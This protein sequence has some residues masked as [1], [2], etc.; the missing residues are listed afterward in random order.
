[1]SNGTTHQLRMAVVDAADI[2]DLSRINRLGQMLEQAEWG[3]KAGHINFDPAWDEYPL[4]RLEKLFFR[5]C[6]RAVVDEGSFF[7]LIVGYDAM[8]SSLCDK[9]KDTLEIRPDLQALV[10]DGEILPVVLEALI[11][12][13]ATIEVMKQE[14]VQ[15]DYYQMRDITANTLFQRGY[16]V[17]E[18]HEHMENWYRLNPAPALQ[19]VEEVIIARTPDQGQARGGE[20]QTLAAMLA[21]S[22]PEDYQEP[23]A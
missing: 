22:K 17:P 12:A 8:F 16:S 13:Q 15:R 20:A 5:A 6:W 2:K 18:V 10:D 4:T 11:E 9:T 21:N 23:V 19:T 3:K 1:V 7:R 14:Q